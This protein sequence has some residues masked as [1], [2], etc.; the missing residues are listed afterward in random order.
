M[1]SGPRLGMY[2]CWYLAP[3]FP[4]QGSNLDVTDPLMSSFI[5]LYRNR[6][7]YHL[8]KQLKSLP[9]KPGYVYLHLEIDRTDYYL[10]IRSN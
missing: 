4:P 6:I 8:W 3:A 2:V 7:P 9:Y 10:S 1:L 5:S